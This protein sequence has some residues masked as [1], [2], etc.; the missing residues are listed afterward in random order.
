MK[1]EFQL[2]AKSVYNI[3]IYIYIYIY[4]YYIIFILV[5]ILDNKKNNSGFTIFFSAGLSKQNSTYPEENFG[6]KISD[7]HEFIFFS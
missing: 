2:S 6:R 7:N 1:S 3:F 5:K 4:I